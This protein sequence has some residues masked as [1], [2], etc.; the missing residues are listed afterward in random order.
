MKRF[1]TTSI[2]LISYLVL[3]AVSTPITASECRELR[4][5]E[6][7]KSEGVGMVHPLRVP[8]VVNGQMIWFR[9]APGNLDCPLLMH[10]SLLLQQIVS[11]KI[12]NA[13][14]F[15]YFIESGQDELLT[16]MVADGLRYVTLNVNFSNLGAQLRR[17]VGDVLYEKIANSVV[18]DF[19]TD[20]YS[21]TSENF[22]IGRWGRMMD[23]VKLSKQTTDRLLALDWFSE[24]TRST[25]PYIFTIDDA[26]VLVIILHNNG[27]GIDE[28]RVI[29]FVDGWYF[30][31][32]LDEHE[33]FT[34]ERAKAIEL[35]S[36]LMK[37]LKRDKYISLRD[38]PIFFWGI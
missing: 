14:N 28:Q 32:P 31:L 36:E 6:H 13:K 5:A 20:P 27:V 30:R 17:A 21:L 29:S 1:L 12:S 24:R 3:L 4:A 7:T 23:H 37:K 18:R 11:G 16:A 25:W 8:V 15:D 33:S 35:I 10:G 9:P 38:L 26:V 22:G 19:L 34:F 2:T